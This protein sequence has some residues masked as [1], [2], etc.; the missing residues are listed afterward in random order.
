[1][2]RINQIFEKLASTA[3][4][5]ATLALVVGLLGALLGSGAAFVAVPGL[6]FAVTGG[7]MLWL[8]GLFQR[9][10]PPEYSTPAD[11]TPEAKNAT[12]I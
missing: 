9:Q 1:M 11:L 5:A 7:L 10:I 12:A 4:H 8:R 6:M 2:N 3:I